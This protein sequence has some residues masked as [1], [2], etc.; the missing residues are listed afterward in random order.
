MWWVPLTTGVFAVAGTI[1]LLGGA[2]KPSIVTIVA[3]EIIVFWVAT[4][5]LALRFWRKSPKA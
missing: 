2:F 4:I 5:W 1:E 3:L